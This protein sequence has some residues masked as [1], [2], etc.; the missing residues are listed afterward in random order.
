M[1]TQQIAKVLQTDRATRFDFQGIFPS[2]QL[3]KTIQ[4]YPAAI[5]ANVDPQGEPGS[6]WCAFYLSKDRKGEFFDSYGLKPD[7]YNQALQDFQSCLHCLEKALLFT[8]SDHR[9]YF[10]LLPKLNTRIGLGK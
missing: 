8:P 6:H 4:R 2:D 9:I 5:V 3:P 1:N 7:D 10:D